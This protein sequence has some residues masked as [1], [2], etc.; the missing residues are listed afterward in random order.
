MQA[1]LP[2]L[3]ATGGTRGIRAPADGR[4]SLANLFDRTV[5]SAKGFARMVENAEPAFR[6]TPERFRA[7]HCRHS[8]MLARV[9]ADHGIDAPGNGTIMGSVNAAVITFRAFFDEIDEDAMDQIRSGEEWVLKAFDE[10]INAQTDT[11]V[12]AHLRE[13]RD[14]LVALLA[15]TR[16]LD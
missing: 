6:D 13:M 10:A 11:A 12:A 14:E 16:D 9:L 7:L 15:D 8:G 2:I 3:Q 5:D 1:I 4:E